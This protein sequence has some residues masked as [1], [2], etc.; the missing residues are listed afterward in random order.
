M[1][2]LRPLAA[3]RIVAMGMVLIGAIVFS[4]RL[5]DVQIMSAPQ[6][7]QDALDKRGVP[8]MIPSVRGDIVDRNGIVLA[9]TEERYDVQLSPKNVRLNGGKFWRIVDD[10][11][12]GT[13]QVTADEAFGEIG[14]ITGQQ[15]E[16]IATIVDEALEENPKSDFAYVKRGVD[17][18]ALNALKQLDIPWMTFDTNPQRVYP[19]GAVAGSIV[20]FIG[21]EGDPQAGVEFS[22]NECLVGVDGEENFEMGA[23]GVRLPGSVVVTREAENGGT[24]KLT[25][26]VDLQYEAQQ[27]LDSQVEKSTAEWGLLTIL[28]ARTGELLAVAEDRSVD[29][30]N[31]SAADPER[32]EARSF[33]WPYEPG[34]TSKVLTAAMLVDQ[35]AANAGTQYLT[36]YAAEPEP[37]VVYSDAFVHDPM[38]WTLNGILVES[39]NVGITALG[40]R[41]DEQARHDYLRKFGL[42]QETSAGMPLESG[43]MLADVTEWDRQTSYNTMFG[44]GFS[45]TIVQTASSYQAIANDGVRVPPTLVS[46]CTES[47][48]TEIEHHGGEESRVISAEAAAQTVDMM[49]NI[50][51]EAWIADELAISGYRLAGKTGTAEQGDGQGGYRSDYVYSFAGLFPADDPQFVIVSTIAYP[52]SQHGTI[53]ATEAW[54]AAAKAVIRHTH[55]P[56]SNGAYQPLPITY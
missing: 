33:T 42:G 36:P 46:S 6:L 1:P 30:N 44:Q 12:I 50:A 35:G 15:P 56:P 9:T 10:G 45:T 38:P 32:R 24:V 17:L 23:D 52:K 16:D 14:A 8:V 34:S 18:T 21:A 7:N 47:D 25:I 51:N 53:A 29:P 40:A 5:V 20:G 39:S 49:E 27:A 22:Q 55:L 41:V 2:K 11:G 43:G 4:V 31:V 28:D 3:R 26:D 13:V 48:G 19:N 37:G 54:N